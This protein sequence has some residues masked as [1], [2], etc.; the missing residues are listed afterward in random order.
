MLAF[1]FSKQRF[2]F[3]HFAV[4][5]SFLSLPDLKKLPKALIFTGFTGTGCL[6]KT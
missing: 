6:L 4:A 5:A 3:C 2:L 1:S